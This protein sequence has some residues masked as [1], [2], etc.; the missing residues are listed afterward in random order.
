[1]TAETLVVWGQDDRLIPPA[2]GERLAEL[3]PN[4]RLELVPECGHLIWFERPA[5]LLEAALAHLGA[6]APA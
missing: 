5:Q 3:I 4:A 2:Y 6:A 1:V